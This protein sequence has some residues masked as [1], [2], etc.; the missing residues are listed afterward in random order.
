MVAQQC[1]P[2]GQHFQDVNDNGGADQMAF[3]KKQF[4]PIAII[5]KDVPDLDFATDM[6]HSGI[7]LS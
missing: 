7:G 3:F 1:G 4:P 6:L 5:Q 2:T